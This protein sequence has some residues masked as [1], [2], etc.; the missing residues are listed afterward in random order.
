MGP[1]SARRTLNGERSVDGRARLRSESHAASCRG[2]VVS[3][4]TRWI[5]DSTENALR[6]LRSEKVRGT[7]ARERWLLFV[8]ESGL[9]ALPSEFA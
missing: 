1:L 5:N 7:V 2:K 3:R 4:N 9:C 8:P 6:V